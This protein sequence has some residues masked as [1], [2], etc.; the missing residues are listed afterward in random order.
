MRY[1][2]I[3]NGQKDAATL[4]SPVVL[5]LLV[6]KQ[7]GHCRLETAVREKRRGEVGAISSLVLSREK[8]KALLLRLTSWRVDG[9]NFGPPFL[10]KRRQVEK[11]LKDIDWGI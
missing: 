6:E 9:I 8:K 2:I 10:D 7:K 1:L 5:C 4:T 3:P 11:W